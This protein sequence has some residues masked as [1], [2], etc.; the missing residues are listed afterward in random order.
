M[1]TRFPRCL[2]GIFPSRRRTRRFSDLW[3]FKISRFRNLIRE[4]RDWLESMWYIVVNRLSSHPHPFWM[5]AEYEVAQDQ[6]WHW[7]SP[8]LRVCVLG[9]RVETVFAIQY[10]PL[11]SSC[12]SRKVAFSRDATSR[13]FTLSR[14]ATYL[15]MTAKGYPQG[16]F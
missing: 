2:I 4:T 7:T 16:K 13:H 5:K 9:L 6:P 1:A 3:Y 15:A 8:E 11:G 10:L 14:D 12:L